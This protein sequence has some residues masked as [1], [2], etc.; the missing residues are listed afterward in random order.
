MSLESIGHAIHRAGL[1]GTERARSEPPA[2]N[3]ESASTGGEIAPQ[4]MTSAEL[5]QY[6][7][8]VRSAPSVREDRIAALRE[9]IARGTYEVPIEALAKRLAGDGN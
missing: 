3:R 2:R 4:W 5:Q 9:A 8:V 6:V 1:G 7:A